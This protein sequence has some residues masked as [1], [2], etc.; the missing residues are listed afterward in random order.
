MVYYFELSTMQTKIYNFF[1]S[2]ISIDFNLLTYKIKKKTY[3]KNGYIIKS[4]SLINMITFVVNEKFKILRDTTEHGMDV[5][6]SLEFMCC[7]YI[8]LEQ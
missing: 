7:L 4:C 6:C 2:Q 1:F 3:G 5:L 8:F